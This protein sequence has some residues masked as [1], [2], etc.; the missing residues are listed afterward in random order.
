MRETSI[1]KDVEICVRNLADKTKC[2]S[3][4]L[5]SE[6]SCLLLPRIPDDGKV[7][8]PSN[9][10]CHPSSSEPLRKGHILIR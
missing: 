5:V 3:T 9:S 4:D 2:M 1:E 8:K 10:V 7:Q 6:T